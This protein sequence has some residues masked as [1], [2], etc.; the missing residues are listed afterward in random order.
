M[1]LHGRC[2]KC[3]QYSTRSCEYR[4]CRQAQKQTLCQCGRYGYVTDHAHEALIFEAAL[5]W[6]NSVS[7]EDLPDGGRLYTL[8]AP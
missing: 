2:L 4:S 1:L 3:S 5:P 6:P 7:V 8:S